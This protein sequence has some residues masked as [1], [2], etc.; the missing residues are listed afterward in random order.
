VNLLCSW[1]TDPDLVESV[2]LGGAY[3]GK[4]KRFYVGDQGGGFS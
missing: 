4:E 1:Y 3:L 2:M